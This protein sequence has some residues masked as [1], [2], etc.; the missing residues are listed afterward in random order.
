MPEGRERSETNP[1]NV[2]SLGPVVSE[3]Q[4]LLEQ[5]EKGLTKTNGKL[6]SQ[7][8]TGATETLTMVVSSE[9]K[10]QLKYKERK[11]ILVQY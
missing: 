10:I 2:I 6:C 9:C 11:L 7:R 5:K 1:L 3:V 4:I 8:K